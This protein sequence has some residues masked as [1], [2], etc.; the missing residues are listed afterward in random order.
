MKSE[1]DQNYDDND[2]KSVNTD[3]LYKDNN[4]DFF[5]DEIMFKTNNTNIK[6]QGKEQG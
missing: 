6:E 4:N 2:I 5:G 1:N 3:E